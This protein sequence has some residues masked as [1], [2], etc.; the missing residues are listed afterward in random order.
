L[1]LT[2]KEMKAGLPGCVQRI[3]EFMGVKL[4][5]DELDLICEKSS[6]RYMKRIDD[7]FHP[8]ILSPWS[9]GTG[10]MMHKGQSGGSSELLVLEQQQR[11]DAY[12]KDEL[13]RFQCDFPYDEFC[14]LAG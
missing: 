13:R 2:Y 7:K 8:G 11:I 6:F 9:S 12:C 5:G 4:S 14:A 1:F 10:R 3:A